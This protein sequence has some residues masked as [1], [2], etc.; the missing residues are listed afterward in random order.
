MNKGDFK[1]TRREI[2]DNAFKLTFEQLLRDDDVEE[3]YEIAEEVDEINVN[4]EVKKI[5]GG[6]I[7]HR[8][9]IDGIISDYSK[10]RSIS[11]ISKLNLAIL[12]I[13]LYEALH[14]E[15]IPVNVA[16]SEAVRLAEV[17][18]YS[19]DISFINGVLGAFSRDLNRK[20]EENA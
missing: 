15:R 1:M 8:E 7:N 14:D 11:R 2:R 18:T 17:Y 12:R 6:V 4:D 10:S 9:E 13:A 19:E 3:L 5:V 20:E 16:I